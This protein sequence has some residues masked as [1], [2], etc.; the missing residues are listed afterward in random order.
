[1]RTFATPIVSI[2]LLVAAIL[3]IDPNTSAQVPPPPGAAGAPV[4]KMDE[5]TQA[6]SWVLEAQRNYRAAIRDYSCVFVAHENMTGKGAEDQI[7]HMKFR[8]QPFSVNMVWARPASMATQEVSYVQGKNEN[9][10]RVKNPGLLKIA[11]F[12]SDRRQR[13]THQGT[14]PAHDPGGRDRQPPRSDRRQLAIRPPERQ[15]DHPDLGLQVRQSRVLADRDDPHRE[16]AAVLFLPRRDLPREEL[17]VSSPQRELPLARPRRQ[18][19]GRAHGELQ[20]HRAPVQQGAQ[21]QRLRSVS[22]RSPHS[23]GWVESS[24]PTD[25]PDIPITHLFARALIL[26]PEGVAYQ[27]PGSRSA[28]WGND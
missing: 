15:G 27:S 25:W 2:V 7:I 22:V 26:Y 11:G 1:M 10:L 12:M 28:P 9:K 20:L 8:Q 16:A 6:L 3:F 14:Q 4:Q 24:R 23:V 5:A 21:G 17:E 18:P 13:Q 19:A